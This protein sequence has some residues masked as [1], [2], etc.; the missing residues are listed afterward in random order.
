[1]LGFD[2]AD[3]FILKE[4]GELVHETT[5]H[6]IYRQELITTWRVDD[7]GN[8][9]GPLHGNLVAPFCL[10][11]GILVCLQLM[12]MGHWRYE[13]TRFIAHRSAIM[14]LLLVILWVSPRV[15]EKGLKYRLVDL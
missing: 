9:H 1:M 13:S 14:S 3:Q 15:I 5:S 4:T 10:S 7:E 8:S 12:M 2:K 6:K 11:F